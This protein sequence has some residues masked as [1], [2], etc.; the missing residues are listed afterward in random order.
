MKALRG[1]VPEIQERSSDN[2]R[3]VVGPGSLRLY[4]HRAV[5][6]EV[7]K[8]SGGYQQKPDC[9]PESHE[10]LSL[11]AAIPSVKV[12]IDAVLPDGA[13]VEG[14]TIALFTHKGS[15]EWDS[16]GTETGSRAEFQLPAGL[17]CKSQVHKGGYQFKAIEPMP[18]FELS[19][20]VF[21]ANFRRSRHLSRSQN[22]QRRPAPPSTAARAVPRF[23][24]T[25]VMDSAGRL[26]A[27]APS[28]GVFRVVTYDPVTQAQA[29]QWQE[30]A[31]K[32]QLPCAV[33]T[34]VEMRRRPRR[35]G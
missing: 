14:C 2:D 30:F 20:D 26:H 29:A 6:G 10:P 9:R 16:A 13:P 11:L 25:R 22:R 23:G 33:A 17:V 18:L 3:M 34:R 4:L 21:L 8:I 19:D 15:V 5:P 24:I 28:A 1:E 32:E 12:V 35:N 31:T 27:Q 7:A